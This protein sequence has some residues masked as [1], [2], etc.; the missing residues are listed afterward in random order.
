[1]GIVD[2]VVEQHVEEVVHV[3]IVQKEK[4]VQ[5][6]VEMVVEVPR[7]QVVEKTIEVPKIQIEEKIIKVPKVTE[8]VIDTLVQHQVQTIEVEK[9]K[10]VTRTVQ[11]K[12]PVIQEHITHVPV[13]QREL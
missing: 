8:T 3:P 7:P 2:V 13:T 10:I 4:I 5:N 6:P 12:K 11:R 1:M 9:P